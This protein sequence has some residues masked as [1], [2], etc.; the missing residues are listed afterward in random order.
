MNRAA[1]LNSF[2]STTCVPTFSSLW[3]ESS[4]YQRNQPVKM[5][6]KY[7]YE[8]KHIIALSL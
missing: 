3:L 6:Q 2:S 8:L 7:I 5:L 1:V 4:A